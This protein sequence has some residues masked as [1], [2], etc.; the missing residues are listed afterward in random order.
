MKE[1]IALSRQVEK[2]WRLVGWGKL[3]RGK[4]DN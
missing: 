4:T 1:K 3:L 2:K